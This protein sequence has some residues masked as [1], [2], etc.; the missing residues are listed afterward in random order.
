VN[1]DQLPTKRSVSYDEVCRIIGELYLTWKSDI[2]GLQEETKGLLEGM[3]NRIQVYAE[4]NARLK[5]VK[6]EEGDI[7]G[8]TSDGAG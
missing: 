7:F 1:A 8:P 5:R 6:R 3:R 2:I 4:E